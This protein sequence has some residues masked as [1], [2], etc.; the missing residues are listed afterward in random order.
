M[1]AVIPVKW[2]SCA[3]LDR[4]P[5]LWRQPMKTPTIRAMTDAGYVSFC[6]RQFV[7]EESVVLAWRTLRWSVD[8]LPEPE[9]RAER[10]L[11]QMKFTVRPQFQPADPWRPDRRRGDE[12]RRAASG[13]GG[14]GRKMRERIKAMR[15]ERSEVRPARPP[16][17]DFSYF[18][19]QARHV[20]ATPADTAAG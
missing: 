10:V 16:G 20:P 8:C 6:V 12:R 2:S 5:G 7:L 3:I 15:Q 19:K 18:I 4:L 13:M 14:R 1:A 9:G 17:R 11:G